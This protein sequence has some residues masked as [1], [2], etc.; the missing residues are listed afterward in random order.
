MSQIVLTIAQ[1]DAATRPFNV[2]DEVIIQD[3][4]TNLFS[5]SGI[6]IAQMGLDNVD[7]IECT[8]DGFVWN[9][10]QAKAIAGTNIR[11]VAA[12]N[13]QLFDSTDNLK[14]LTPSELAALAQK[15][16]DSIR[17][18]G[19]AQQTYRVDQ[20][21][22]LGGIR[23]D[24]ADQILIEDDS[25]VLSTLTPAELDKLDNV[26]DKILS[27][28]GNPIALSVVQLAVLTASN[29]VATD[30]VVLQ[31]S[32]DNLQAL[33]PNGIRGMD[34][35]G[36]DRIDSTTDDTL[37]LSVEQAS[38]LLETTIELTAGD[39]VILASL[40]TDL[41]ML[42]GTLITQLAARGVDEI[43]VTGGSTLSLDVA[44]VK[45]LATTNIT[46]SA[47]DIV[48]LADTAANLQTLSPAEIKK[49][50]VLGLD[51]IGAT[52]TTLVL[53]VDQA[54]ALAS[55]GI[56][57]T[58]EKSVIV[59]GTSQELAAGLNVPELTALAAKGVDVL[60]AEGA[61][62]LVLNVAEFNALGGI[63]LSA[64]D[65]KIIIDAGSVIGALSPEAIA[66]FAAKGIDSIVAT[67]NPG[68][69]SLSMAQLNALG[70]VALTAGN[71]VT[72][73]DTAANLQALTPSEIFGLNDKLID[74]IDSTDNTLSLS[75][76]QA[77][78]LLETQIGL[79]TD[80]VVTLADTAASLQGL[81]PEL[82]ADLAGKGI[83]KIDVTSSNGEN[84]S[85]TLSVAQAVGLLATNITLSA[86]DIVTLAGTA[87]NLQ[88]LDPDQIR[89]LGVKGIDKIDATDSVLPL[90]VDQAVALAGTGIVF[91]QGDI[92]TVSGTFAELTQ[93][94]NVDELTALAAKGDI[95]LDST[96]NANAFNVAEFNA[97]GGIKLAA[98]DVTTIIDSA[99]AFEGLSPEQIAKFAQKGIDSIQVTGDGRLSLTVD[100]FNALGSVGLTTTNTVTLADTAAKLQALSPAGILR[101]NDKFIDVIDST[102][103]TL[104]LSVEQA[105]T[106]LPTQI[107]LSADD[108]VTLADTAANLQGLT[109][110]LIA[111][112]A[113]KGIDKVDATGN[114]LAL[115]VAQAAA[116]AGANITVAADDVVTLADTSANLQTLSGTQ[117]T[118]LAAKG[119]DLI[120]VTNQ[121]SQD[122]RLNLS[123][124]QAIA[125]AN[126]ETMKIVAGD[127]VIL[128][129]TA[130]DL[131]NLSDDRITKLGQKG[132]DV[133]D[134]EGD[135][136]ALSLS[137][138]QAKALAN[139]PITLAANDDVT[140]T[141]TLTELKTLSGTQLSALR[142][143][144]VDHFVVTNPGNETITLTVAQLD[145][146]LGVDVTGL[147]NVVL[148]DTGAALGGLSPEK[149]AQLANLD[150]VSLNASNDILVLNLAQLN[151][152]GAVGLT[153][154][155]SITMLDTSAWLAE[156]TGERISALAVQG[157]DKI[158]ALDDEWNMTIA[159]A[160]ALAA[161]GISLG[162]ADDVTL[163]GMA[164][165]LASLLLSEITDLGKKNLDMIDV[166]SGN[167]ILSA[168]QAAVLAG[169]ASLRFSAE[170]AVTA[171]GTGAS[172]AALTVAQMGAL[173]AKGID[174]LDASDNQLRLSRA[175]FA[176]LGDVA[177]TAGDAVTV[178]GT[179]ADLAGFTSAQI[180]ALGAKG[181]D[182]LDASDNQLNLSVAQFAALG[183]LALTAGDLVSLSDTG[184]NLASLTATQIGALAAKG[185]DALDA[186]SDQLSL[187]FAQFAALGDVALTAGDT[188][189][190]SDTGAALAGVAAAEI[191]ALAAKG[192]D[193]LDA[194]DNV[195][196]FSLEQFNALGTLSLAADDVI[197]VQGT[198]SADTFIGKNVDQVFF[199]LGGNDIIRGSAGDTTLSGGAGND[200]L[201]GGSGHDTFVFDMRPNA[202]SNKDVI[203]NW[204]A[205]SDTIQLENA[206]FAK[207]SRTGVLNKAYF[208]NN[209]VAKDAN[210]YVGYDRGTGNLWYD[211]NG[212]AAGG[213]VVFANIGRNKTIGFAD[214]VVI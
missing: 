121:D 193:G 128:H 32:A 196:N 104:S 10:S 175:Q 48:T 103:N 152:L 172:L 79:S 119:I 102:E 50:G 194:S 191:G 158:N 90:T 77:V 8:G 210:D 190:L 139:T 209:A 132:V 9:V 208:T 122:N 206:V 214:F 113:G 105:V 31:D 181:V 82:I 170:D 63:A 149:V 75:V 94:L 164:A 167:L 62:S 178:F 156:L 14:T 143:K 140:L 27:R 134:A 99:A 173:S 115:T 161:T 176:A 116:L 23:L 198:L 109:P 126:T 34:E 107:R 87:A 44:Q 154:A 100:Q 80:D 192:V 118:Q 179:G 92:V 124:A 84:N 205:A 49:L 17:S 137:F 114:V 144:G 65:S 97:L 54:A 162:A 180:G 43:A 25:V 185:I 199:G 3:T 59:R 155:D 117:I 76:N 211:S 129:A 88:T 19:P 160:K 29:F 64:D 163:K 111:Q 15:G 55:T 28:D 46:L 207:L 69:L 37:R 187:S 81:A 53:T 168:A 184:A 157:V 51:K 40:D 67:G 56:G 38:A 138:L 131:Q 197:K 61:G 91:A 125:L 24:A 6:K 212:S 171:S 200:R 4:A 21:K 153:A 174:A 68:E 39:K 110:E 7:F 26:D 169:T 58:S 36:V 20:F 201:Y 1:Y 186:S 57:F 12:D 135:N 130:A 22:A 148:T 71:T 93:K 98:D 73:A 177:L 147:Q 189:S 183:D 106:L 165:E 120:D 41:Q 213:Q 60:D 86:G 30:V 47:D 145:A 11:F 16:L 72:L 85:L 150:V 18:T 2:E 5:L 70:S 96:D 136:T 182:A 127:D 101:L 78:T 188:V 95:T 13:V 74:F 66:R 202:R 108:V 89:R 45:A 33:S 133:I 123:I 112:L 204:S 35:K 146:L 83:D 166:T 141:L 42:S 203:A 159:Q 151:A 195:I 52:D 142:A